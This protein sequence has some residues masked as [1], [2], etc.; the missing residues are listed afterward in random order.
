MRSPR[1]D[2]LWDELS[3]EEIFGV[4]GE[5]TRGEIEEEDED[6]GGSCG[7]EDDL[8]LSLP[9]EEDRSTLG[10]RACGERA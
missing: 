6:V 2:R 9:L 10:W 8:P 1:P 5:E 3:E 4:V 7:R